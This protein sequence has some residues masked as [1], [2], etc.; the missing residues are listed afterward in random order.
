MSSL[1]DIACRI[2]PDISC[3]ISE[4]LHHG[5]LADIESHVSTKIYC[6]ITAAALC[7]TSKDDIRYRYMYSFLGFYPGIT[8][9][10]DI[11]N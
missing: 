1:A 5:Y 7:L 2:S 6:H 4:V 3:C 9:D 8:G 11:G 10:M